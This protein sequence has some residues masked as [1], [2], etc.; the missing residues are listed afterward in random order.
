MILVST[1][2]AVDASRAT[3][4][5]SFHLPEQFA[6]ASGR[7]GLLDAISG[8]RIEQVGSNVSLELSPRRAAVPL[9]A[10]PSNLSSFPLVDIDSADAPLYADT[11]VHL[12][13]GAHS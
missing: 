4:Q 12:S 2:A 1:Q 9:T 5:I 3:R 11:E 13:Q 7:V 6:T 10:E 8:R